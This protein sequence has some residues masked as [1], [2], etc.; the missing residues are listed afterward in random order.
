MILLASQ[1][2]SWMPEERLVAH[3]SHLCE[4]L[5]VA[6]ENIFKSMSKTAFLCIFT[7]CHF[8]PSWKQG[9][10]CLPRLG[11]LPDVCRL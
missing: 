5:T 8:D 6:H 4:H 1:V 9:E 10:H 11:W 2:F 7:L 3:W